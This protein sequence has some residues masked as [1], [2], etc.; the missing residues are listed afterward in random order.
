M[1]LTTNPLL[2]MQ[3]STR[4]AI[5]EELFGTPLLTLWK[6]HASSPERYFNKDAASLVREVYDRETQ[7]RPQAVQSALDLYIDQLDFAFRSL[8]ELNRQQIHEEDISGST[9][10]RLL[11][12]DQHLIP[13][14]LKGMEWCLSKLLLPLAHLNVTS[15][16]G[17][18]TFSTTTPILEEIGRSPLAHLVSSFSPTVRNAIA[19]GGVRFLLDEILFRDDKGNEIT[20][21]IHEF[22]E[23]FD[24]LIDLCNSLALGYECVLSSRWQD[25][26]HHPISFLLELLRSRVDTPYWQVRYA[27]TSKNINSDDQLNIMVRT[28]ESEYDKIQY[29]AIMTACSSV[30]LSVEASRVFLEISN[31]R[32][33]NQGWMSFQAAPLRRFIKSSPGSREYSDTLLES[34]NEPGL[35]LMKI[36]KRTRLRRLRTLYQSFR[37]GIDALL[38]KYK[39]SVRARSI[40]VRKSLR[41]LAKPWT[42]VNASCVVAEM[43]IRTTTDFVRSNL[44]RIVWLCCFRARLIPGHRA[45]AKLFPV[46]FARIGVYCSNYRVRELG[47]NGLPKDLIC[48]IHFQRD[49]RVKCPD[50]IGGIS[51]QH[52]LYRIIW[53]SVWIEAAMPDDPKFTHS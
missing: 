8:S 38:V 48:M 34:V 7:R 5:I 27:Q 30:D 44:S 12:L 13:A 37:L 15:R 26:S 3:D 6:Y 52:G 2:S 14:Y 17:T 33:R 23:N 9:T 51:E 20:L 41:H 16:N 25:L 47:V 24:R 31:P 32:A 35:F 45:V 50:I 22:I 49:K 53:N 1:S 28:S 40:E 11:W 42:T 29:L 19:H 4:L 46:G 10:E 43:D 18:P 39:H 36:R 21:A